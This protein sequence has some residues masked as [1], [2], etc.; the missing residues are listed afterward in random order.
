MW[1][2]ERDEEALSDMEDDEAKDYLY[3]KPEAAVKEQLWLAMNQ[4]YVEKQEAKKAI[5]AAEQVHQCIFAESIRSWCKSDSHTCEPY[6][7]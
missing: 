4:E 2:A 3:S 1:N 6:W 5:Q 7:T